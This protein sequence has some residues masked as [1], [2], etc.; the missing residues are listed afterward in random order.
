LVKR[1]FHGS[2][3]H[4]QD[5]LRHFLR[6]RSKLPIETFVRAYELHPVA[7]R[8]RWTDKKLIDELGIS[9][10]QLKRFRELGT[11]AQES[12]RANLSREFESQT[13]IEAVYAIGFSVASIVNFIR[14][15]VGIQPKAVS[16]QSGRHFLASIIYEAQDAGFSIP[17]IRQLTRL[18]EKKITK[19]IDERAKLEPIIV[20]GLRMLFNEPEI[21]RP[22]LSGK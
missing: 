9:Y 2:N 5:A 21:E 11:L 12:P 22:Y 13:S 18:E 20:E 1:A 7:E 16:I 8:H 4:L 6:S 3:Q 19:C 17:E 15:Y 14:Q 10:T